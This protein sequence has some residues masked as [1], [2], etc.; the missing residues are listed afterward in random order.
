M[1]HV[2]R[3][4]QNNANISEMLCACIFEL[5]QIKD[6]VFRRQYNQKQHHKDNTKQESLQG[7]HNKYYK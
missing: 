5:L 2:G 7:K 4:I 3:D 6:S 1:G